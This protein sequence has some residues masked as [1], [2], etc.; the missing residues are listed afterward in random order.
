MCMLSTQA[1]VEY[2]CGSSFSST[3]CPSTTHDPT[4]AATPAKTPAATQAAAPAPIPAKTPAATTAATPA[5]TSPPAPKQVPPSAIEYLGLVNAAQGA[6]KL[7]WDK[8]SSDGGCPISYVVQMT[9]D[10]KSSVIT[11]TNFSAQC[12]N[13]TD[14]TQCKD[15][16]FSVAAV[17][18]AGKSQ[19]ATLNV[20]AGDIGVCKA[21]VQAVEASRLGTPQRQRLDGATAVA[22]LL[23]QFSSIPELSALFPQPVEVPFPLEV[24]TQT[25]VLPLA[26]AK[27]EPTTVCASCNPFVLSTPVPAPMVAQVYGKL[28]ASVALSSAPAR[29]LASVGITEHV[30]C[31]RFA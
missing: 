27:P 4:P 18:C 10:G 29:C 21:N 2:F 16:T 25:A 31:P 19:A 28:K 5:P 22:H 17:N 6:V 24:K 12:L 30:R 3:P 26:V 20:A 11:P 7:C 23:P 15:I 13:L 1:S 14:V 8:P 9:M